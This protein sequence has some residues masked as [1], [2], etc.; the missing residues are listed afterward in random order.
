VFLRLG[1]DVRASQLPLPLVR[2]PAPGSRVP[3]VDVAIVGSGFAGTILA[4]VLRASGRS[5]LLIDR[6]RHPRFALGESSTPLAAVLLERLAAQSGLADLADLATWGRWQRACPELRCGL[7]RGFTFY[8][9]GDGAAAKRR[10]LVAASPDDE[11]ADV[12]HHRADVD[13]ALVARARSEGVEVWEGVEIRWVEVSSTGAE[14][15]VEV[16]GSLERVRTG[17]VVDATGPSGVVAR[18]LGAGAVDSGLAGGFL[19]VHVSGL[20]LLSEVDAAWGGP[21]PYPAEKAAV[22]HLLADG[23]MWVLRFDD[24]L[25]S[26]GWV[27]DRGPSLAAL[28]AGR[29]ATE[30][31]AIALR[32]APELASAWSRARV[33]TPWAVAPRGSHRLD[34]ATGPGWL[35]LPHTVAFADPMFSTGLAWS[36][37][38]VER[39]VA[40]LDG[41]LDAEVYDAALRREADRIAALIAAARATR[42]C[43]GAF[44]AVCWV[45]FATVSWAEVGSRLGLGWGELG[46]TAGFLGVGD[47]AS[48]RLFAGGLELGWD[49]LA[50]AA[51]RLTAAGFVGVEAFREQ[52]ARLLAPR[53]LIGI[54]DP[55]RGRL[56]PADLEVLV[57]RAALVGLGRDDMRALL[58]RLRG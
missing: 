13:A 46:R 14:L 5:V 58:P 9:H 27:L 49:G 42:P 44:E 33:E 7:K 48:D 57:D 6:A 21:A 41:R 26:V 43:F 53:D 28:E 24:G 12:Q 31:I 11:I 51:E 45:Y 15:T 22:H 30:V 35:A 56:H 52:I 16:D 38:G 17:V 32:Q 37:L 8:D 19:G 54:T 50:P 40:V 25:A 18:R 23:W 34:R 2:I 1:A 47:P 39:V 3:S 36:L 29:P 4:R 10:L 55:R 20:P